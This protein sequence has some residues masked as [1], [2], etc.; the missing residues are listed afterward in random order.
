MMQATIL[1]AG[2]DAS[3]AERVRATQA[4]AGLSETPRVHRGSEVASVS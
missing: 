2:P 4:V 3:F 1:V